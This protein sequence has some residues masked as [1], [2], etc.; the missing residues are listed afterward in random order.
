M[1]RIPTLIPSSVVESV[2]NILSGSVADT[3]WKIGIAT[4]LA[5]FAYV[6]IASLGALGGFIGA[7]LLSALIEDDIRDIVV[8]IWNRDFW[9]WRV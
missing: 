9:I 1:A 5:V 4:M 6:L 8:D 2:G 7:I 3:I